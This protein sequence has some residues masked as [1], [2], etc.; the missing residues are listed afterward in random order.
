MEN[1]PVKPGSLQS[2]N[3]IIVGAAIIRLYPS[4]DAEISAETIRNETIL[5]DINF[6][7]VNWREAHRYVVVNNDIFEIRKMGLDPIAP[8]RRFRKGPK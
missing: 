3:H 8:V 5:S 6:M 2:G 4:L 1:G 7:G